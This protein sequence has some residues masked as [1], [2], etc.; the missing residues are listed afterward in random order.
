MIKQ[1]TLFVWSV[2]ALM[3]AQAFAAREEHT[4]EVSVDIPTL[5]FYVI[6]AES[7]WIHL[8]QTLPWNINTSTLGGLRKNFDVKH[9]TSAIEA[10]LEA[11]P[12]LSNGRAEQN[13]YLRV[14]FNGRE[15]N[16]DPQPREVVSAAEAMAGGRYALEIVPRVPVGGYQPGTYYGSVNLIFNAAAP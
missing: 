16:H 1:S 15:L 4:F 12:Y 7:N 8:Q 13:I 10:R 14:S 6:P 2:M 3:S 11:E 9:D 5:G